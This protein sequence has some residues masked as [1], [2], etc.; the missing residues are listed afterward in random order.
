[1]LMNRD[2]KVYATAEAHCCIILEGNFQVNKLQICY[3]IYKSFCQLN[4]GIEDFH[5]HSSIIQLMETL[6]WKCPQPYSIP[7][8]ETVTFRFVS[9]WNCTAHL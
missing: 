1:M 8:V 6:G 7:G 3:C 4:D 5:P 9:L 2:S